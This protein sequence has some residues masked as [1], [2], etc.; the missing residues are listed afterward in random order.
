MKVLVTGASGMLGRVT[1]ALLR[2][3]GHEVRAFQ[4]RP[5]GLTGID[6]CLGSVT[7]STAV[8][9]AVQGR[10]AVV[11]L[12][13]KVSF[14]GAAADFEAVNVEGTRL[15]LSAARSAGVRDV[16]FVSSPS[17]A[18]VGEALVG[19]GATQATPDLVRGNYAQT[20]ARAE[21]LALAA[22][23]ENFRVAAVRPHIVWG[24]G[25]TQLV[26]RVME[27]ARA[28]RLPFLDAGTALVDTTY[29]DNAAAA[30]AAALDGVDRLAGQAVVVTNGEPRPIGELIAG[31]CR[32]GGVQPPR[33]SVPG[34]MARVAGSLVE[35]VWQRGG[36]ESEPPMTRFLAEQL[37]TA[38]WFDQRR[39]RE[40]LAWTP[41]V[42]IDEGLSRL[43]LHYQGR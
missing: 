40:L 21:L 34:R 41:T 23:S 22:S 33:W 1:A 32:A 20:K 37:S 11:H 6:D 35:F 36:I 24:P 27:R 7:D 15:L 14:A 25:D 10:D 19:Q 3:Q 29:V 4:R 8:R 28:G 26:E 30:I 12:A 13:A 38:H 5:S 17:V 31:I 43:A 16:V 2:S 39:T 9:R 18:H 42:S